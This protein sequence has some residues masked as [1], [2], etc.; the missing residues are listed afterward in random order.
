MTPQVFNA[1]CRILLDVEPFPKPTHLTSHLGPL[2]IPPAQRSV[3]WDLHPED[4]TAYHPGVPEQ[5]LDFCSVEC[6]GPL[7]PKISGT[8]AWTI[9]RVRPPSSP[10]QQTDDLMTVAAVL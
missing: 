3:G 2:D 6:W 4:A 9:E 1:E 7:P 8:Y 5:P 10:L